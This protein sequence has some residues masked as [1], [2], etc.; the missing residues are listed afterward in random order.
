MTD[1][2]AFVTTTTTSTGD[3]LPLRPALRFRWTTPPGRSGLLPEHHQKS[4]LAFLGA[5]ISFLKLIAQ[6]PSSGAFAFE[7][8]ERQEFFDIV[9]Q[10]YLAPLSMAGFGAFC[11]EFPVAEQAK[12]L[13]ESLLNLPADKLPRQEV[14]IIHTGLIGAGPA[15]IVASPRPPS[16]AGEGGGDSGSCC[17]GSK[18]PPTPKTV[19]LGRLERIERN[20]RALGGVAAVDAGLVVGAVAGPLADGGRVEGTTGGTNDAG[21]E[22]QAGMVSADGKALRVLDV[23]SVDEVE[24][25]NAVVSLMDSSSGEE[26]EVRRTSQQSE[27]WAIVKTLLENEMGLPVRGVFEEGLGEKGGYVMRAF[28]VVEM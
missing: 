24:A 4:L 22:G 28:Y 15:T 8:E 16:G 23:L 14:S 20:L 1:T 27:E 12:L 26:I 11:C 17:D 5:A 10:H 21:V 2:D 3:L 18:Q 25:G 19:V 9:D 6:S 7:K 13:A